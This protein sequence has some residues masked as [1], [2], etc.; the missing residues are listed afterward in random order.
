MM[1]EPIL[2]IDEAPASET[3]APDLTALGYRVRAVKNGAEGVRELEAAR[4]LL[5]VISGDMPD[6]AKWVDAVRLRDDA[7]PL[8]MTTTAS[9]EKTMSRFKG[10][11]Q[12]FLRLPAHPLVLETTLDRMETKLGISSWQYL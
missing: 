4:P 11:A 6:S 8:L 10:L 2:L 3:V 12:E 7:L 1:K 9:L 5:V